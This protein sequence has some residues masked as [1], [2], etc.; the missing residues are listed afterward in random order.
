MTLA[1]TS[2][3]DFKPLPV[4]P[5][6]ARWIL[7]WMDE[8]HARVCST[9]AAAMAH[10][11]GE[12]PTSGTWLRCLPIDKTAPYNGWCLDWDSAVWWHNSGIRYRKLVRYDG[13]VGD[14]LDP[15]PH[16]V[17]YDKESHR[18][19]EAPWLEVL[20]IRMGEGVIT[21]ETEDGEWSAE[22]KPD[23]EVSRWDRHPYRPTYDLEHFAIECH[24]HAIPKDMMAW[25]AHYVWA[26]AGLRPFYKTSDH[27]AVFKEDRMGRVPWAIVPNDEYS[28]ICECARRIGLAL[29]L[30][31]EV[32]ALDNRAMW[33]V[34]QTCQ[35]CLRR[36]SANED[37][38]KPCWK[39]KGAGGCCP[40]S[41][42]WDRRT[43][44]KGL[45]EKKGR[46]C[47][48]EEDDCDD[49]SRE[50]D[51]RAGVGAQDPHP[52]PAQVRP[53]PEV[54]GRPPEGH[55]RDLRPDGL[56]GEH[57]RP[58]VGRREGEVRAHL[59]EAPPMKADGHEIQMEALTAFLSVEV[60]GTRHV[61]EWH[62]AREMARC[63]D[64]LRMRFSA[65]T[66]ELR[67]DSLRGTM[68]VKTIT[69]ASVRLSR[70][71]AHRMAEGARRMADS[72]DDW[73]M[74]REM[75][76]WRRDA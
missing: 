60:D 45:K 73:R 11:V 29:E 32:P 55:L 9:D 40:R 25:R 43:P 17:K 64:G 56:R 16:S 10:S 20:G 33:P 71:E 15:W 36:G 44:A 61:V 38:D 24:R 66:L 57:R 42:M 7:G 59:Q 12:I 31:H 41:W 8:G 28:Q 39:R 34:E 22:I 27:P 63:L 6:S 49:D 74:R 50:R 52:P 13:T 1:Q 5:P 35:S 18:Y 69:G 65:E 58:G 54:A 62:D 76:R 23:A 46:K 2:I 70:D 48:C 30:D 53:R 68:T 72:W 51:G 67:W 4:T 75:D 14:F 19:N 3:F 37:P 26:T 47:Q 21:F